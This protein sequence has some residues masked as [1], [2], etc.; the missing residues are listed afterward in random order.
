MHVGII[1]AGTAGLRCACNLQDKGVGVTV[2]EASQNIGGLARS[3]EWHGFTCDIATHRLFSSDREILDAICRMTPM[4]RHRRKSRIYF[5]QSWMRDPLD[6]VELARATSISRTMQLLRSYYAKPRITDPTSFREFVEAKYGYEL[7]DFFFRPYTEKLFGIPGD[8]ISVSWGR[9]KVR[10]AGP[11]D[12]F[13][14]RSKTK[15]N[16]FYYPKVGGYGAIS[17]SLHGRIRDQVKLGC[18]VTAVQTSD[19][20]IVGLEYANGSHQGALTVDALVSTAPITTTGRLLGHDTALGYR[21]LHAVYLLVNKPRVTDN[22]WIYF[23]DDDIC[24]NRMVEFKNMSDVGAPT[25]TTV[26]CAE[27]TNVGKDDLAACAIDGLVRAG[28]LSEG[29]VLDSTVVSEPFAYPLYTREYEG[30]LAEADRH[31]DR[32]RNLFTMGRAANF[33]HHEIDDNFGAARDITAKVVSYLG[34]KR[35]V[36]STLQAVH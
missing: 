6:V 24:I 34:P 35:A 30:L 1:G 29:E 32:F 11:L 9:S 13:R 23:M 19:D 20:K 10:L 26:L 16:H 5:N 22:H 7:Y 28:L 18:R 21:E 33:A 15:F 8:E 36:G 25:D 14:N 2:F 4:H 27:L 3:F 17:E 12:R 31:L